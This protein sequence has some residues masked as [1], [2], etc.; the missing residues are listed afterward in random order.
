METTEIAYVNGILTKRRKNSDIEDLKSKVTTLEADKA[1]LQ[2]TLTNAQDTIKT[3][4]DTLKSAQDTLDLVLA[5]N[6]SMQQQLD[7]LTASNLK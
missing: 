6:L 4:Q 1:T 2:Q 5:D 7:T 3:T